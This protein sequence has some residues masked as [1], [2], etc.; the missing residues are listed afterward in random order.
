M[1]RRCYALS[2]HLAALQND[3]RL[4]KRLTYLLLGRPGGF[5]QRTPQG[6][7]AAAQPIADA[8]E[9]GRGVLVEHIDCMMSAP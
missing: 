1:V 2:E 9:A 7:T 8:K 6:S 5:L 3:A 4:D